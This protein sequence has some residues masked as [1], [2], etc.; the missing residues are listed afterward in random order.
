MSPTTRTAS[1]ASG[2]FFLL[3]DEPEVHRPAAGPGG[4]DARP[5][6]GVGGDRRGGGRARRRAGRG[7]AAAA[8]YW[9]DSCF[10]VWI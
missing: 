5:G 8:L 4:D 3:L 9:L 1:A 2:A 10:A 6:H 7:R